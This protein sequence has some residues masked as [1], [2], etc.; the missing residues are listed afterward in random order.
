MA[1]GA[2]APSFGA[3]D[4]LGGEAFLAQPDKTMVVKTSRMTS[5][6]VLPI[7]VSPIKT[8]LFSIIRRASERRL[9][10]FSV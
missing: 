2:A 7:I 9:K 4:V 1:A 3:V 10:Y 5:V 6:P 8:E